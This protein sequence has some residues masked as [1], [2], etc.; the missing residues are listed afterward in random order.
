MAVPWV[1]RFLTL[2]ALVVAVVWRRGPGRLGVRWWRR[3]QVLGVALIFGLTLVVHGL[4]KEHWGRARPN[5]VV[6]LGG[7]ATFTPPLRPTDQCRTNCSFVS[8]HAGTGFDLAAFGL[9]GSTAT[10]RRWFRIGAA[11]GLVLGLARMAQGDHFASDVLF[12]G[13]IIWGC[14]LVVRAVWLR[15]VLRRRR[16]R[17][18]LSRA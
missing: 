11:T 15:T 12:S 18:A 1:G 5:A 7:S 6:E 3:W 2:V 13:L 16:R 8:G 9:L 10:R 4:A 17:A 14:N